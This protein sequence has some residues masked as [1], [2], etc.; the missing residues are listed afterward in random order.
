MHKALLTIAAAVLLSSCSGKRQQQETKDPIPSGTG[1]STGPAT[2]YNGIQLQENGLHVQEA[3]LVNEN[4]ERLPDDNTVGINEKIFCE[5]VIS[6]YS[7]KNGKVRV[8]AS[9]EIRAED[10]TLVLQEKDL[11]ASMGELKSS[12]AR[13]VR[14]MAMITALRKS[15]RYF[16]VTFRVWDKNSKADVSGRYRFRLR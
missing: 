7:E 6:G 2:V 9:E 4:G 12:D 10:G 15:Y 16:E 8:G 14:L 1:A 11:F 3:Y 13:Y 5:L